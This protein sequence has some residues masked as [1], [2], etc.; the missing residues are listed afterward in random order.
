M[1]TKTSPKHPICVTITQTTIHVTITQIELPNQ[2][3]HNTDHYLCNHNTDRFSITDCSIQ[4][5]S[6]C[7]ALGTLALCSVPYTQHIHRPSLVFIRLQLLA[8]PAV[9]H[10]SSALLA[11]AQLN[12][13]PLP[14]RSTVPSIAPVQL[15]LHV[16]LLPCRMWVG[17]CLENRESEPKA[18][19]NR[20][21]LENRET[22]QGYRCLDL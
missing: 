17:G 19:M 8:A 11:S 20:A 10:W 6:S 2:C 7:S 1:P 18:N 4:P 14:V 3:N 21:Y 13:C 16:S 5:V 12:P 9:Y 22:E 15:Q